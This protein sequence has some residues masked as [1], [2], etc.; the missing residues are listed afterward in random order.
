M[1]RNFTVYIPEPYDKQKD[2]KDHP[3]KR[4]VIALGRRVGKTTLARIVACEAAL[5]GRR[6]LYAAPTQDQTDSFWDGV[7]ESFRGP[8]DARVFHKN[9]TSRIIEIPGAG[10][11][12]AKTA[13]NAD[14][15]RGDWADLLLLDEFAM[16]EVDAWDLVGA[17]MLLDNDGDAWFM[18]TPN[19][20]NHFYQMFMRAK[21]DGVRWKEWQFSSYDNP[22]LSKEALDEITADMTEAAFRQE[23]MAQFLDNEGSV[24]R[25]IDACTKAVAEPELGSH[26]GHFTVAGLDW[27]QKQDY[28]A[29]SIGCA[30]CKTEIARLRTRSTSYETQLA[31]VAGMLKAWNVRVLIPEENSIGAPLIEKMRSDARFDG[32]TVIPFMMTASSKPT[33]IRSLAL[34]LEDELFQW[35]DDKIWTGELEAYEEKVSTRTG[36]VSFQAPEGVHDDTVIARALCYRAARMTGPISVEQYR[37]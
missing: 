19:R 17:P 15:L 1:P 3:A 14:T 28:T 4:K 37:W 25:N 35:Q 22:F 24:F 27:G 26:D 12:K 6:I 23:I 5:A 21:Q 11:I 33:L 18:S 10:R 32:V 9:E 2:I 34:A 30:D 7:K 29:L 36:H 31:R 16:M 20:R 8:V 13:W